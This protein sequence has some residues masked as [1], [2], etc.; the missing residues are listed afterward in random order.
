[1]TCITPET[2]REAIRSATTL[3]DLTEALRA[4]RRLA[5]EDQDQIDWS[6]LPNFGGPA[7]VNTAGVWSWDN[8]H[9]L[10]GTCADDLE[11]VERVGPEAAGVSII[12]S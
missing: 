10:V 4:T 12:G 1:M 5:P 11:I 9:L 6:D 8:G 3:R 2:V 7:P